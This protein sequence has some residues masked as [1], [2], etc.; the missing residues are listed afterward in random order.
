MQTFVRIHDTQRGQDMDT[1]IARG[2]TAHAHALLLLRRDGIPCVFFGDLYGLG[3]PYPEPPTCSGKLPGIILARKLYAYGQQTDYFERYDC[4]GWTRQ[5]TRRKPDGMAVILSWTMAEE[6]ENIGPQ[7]SM[8]VGKK[9]AGET[10]TDVLGFEWRAVVINEDGFGMF[11]CQWNS[12]ACFVSQNAAGR[13]QFPVRFN[14]EF[15]LTDGTDGA[16]H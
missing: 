10:W 13:A 15:F 8:Y 4:I 12:M 11:P 5:G 14:S 7:L 6:P 2:F 3:Y 1:P 16:H 9:H